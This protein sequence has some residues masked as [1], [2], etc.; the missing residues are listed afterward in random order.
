[1]N[2]TRL[3]LALALLGTACAPSS[4]E[5]LELESAQQDIVRGAVAE[6]GQLMSTVALVDSGG[7]EFFCTGT[8][9]SPR[10]VITAAHCFMNEDQ[11]G[12]IQADDL[13]IGVATLN[14]APAPARQRVAVERFT[15]HQGFGQGGE[16]ADES[17]V[18]KDDDI[19]V[20]VLSAPVDAQAPT[21]IL[22]AGRIADL[23][24]GVM[25]TVSGYGVTDLNPERDRAGTLHIG[26]TR[27]IRRSEHELLAGGGEVSDTCNGDSGGPA[28]VT[29]DGQRYLVGA[30]AR[31]AHDAQLD[32]GDR[33]IYTLVPA[34]QAWIDEVV[35]N[36]PAAQADPPNL[37][38]GF[39]EE[40]EWEEGE[41][42]EEGEWEEGDGEPNVDVCDEEG[43]YGDEVCDEFCDRPDPDCGE[44]EAPEV[45]EPEVE[46]P[47]VE[48]PEVEEPE[49]QPGE[50][51][52]EEPEFEQPED[53][54]VPPPAD[55]RDEPNPSEGP[56]LAHEPAP[57]APSPIVEE[58]VN[59][60][61]SATPGSGNAPLSAFALLL[62]GAFRRR[63]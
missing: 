1:M 50:P 15:V 54:E 59:T 57:S 27:L 5:Q 2:P 3:T 33:G 48:E 26:E 60:G 42:G 58:E 53:Y 41:W 13:A 55:E 62:L 23:Q 43:W 44:V 18:G 32:C 39:G 22:P 30:T 28:Y 11:S 36:G 52:L 61:C 51:E 38:G 24:A 7:G 19:A 14:A 4:S 25:M 10:V 20:V 63:R 29:L 56:G 9:V 17:G 40:G 47:E 16:G 31:A 49:V 35:A 37:E 46:E 45:E 34:Y 12:W 6:A 21:P 8:L